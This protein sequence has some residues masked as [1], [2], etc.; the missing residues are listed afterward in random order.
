MLSEQTLPSVLGYFAAMLYHPNNVTDE[1]AP[2][3]VKLELEV[4][5]MVAEMLG[6]NP[7]TA[8][9]HLCSGG[10]VANLETLWVARAAQFVPFVAASAFNVKRR[11]FATV[12]AQLGLRPNIFVSEAAHYSVKKAA[13]LLIRQEGRRPARLRRGR[14]PPGPR[15][16]PLPPRRA[17]APHHPV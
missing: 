7:R 12:I 16:R 10:T 4:G 3:T 1:A 8:W 11:G 14:H 13:D 2:V 9:T 15:H 17:P 6:Y 5:Q